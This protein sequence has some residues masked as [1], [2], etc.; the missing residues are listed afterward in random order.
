MLAESIYK[1]KLSPTYSVLITACSRTPPPSIHPRSTRFATGKRLAFSANKHPAKVTLFDNF[2]N[3][4]RLPPPP[5]QKILANYLSLHIL[6][7]H[8]TIIP[9]KFIK[10]WNYFVVKFNSVESM[11]E[12]TGTSTDSSL[13]TL[14]CR[15]SRRLYENKSPT[16]FVNITGGYLVIF[17]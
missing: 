4:P 5:F 8:L 14:D 10:M 17:L 12:G 2:L 15:Q 3:W 13:K 6:P 9:M 11:A 7:L 1:P 16:I